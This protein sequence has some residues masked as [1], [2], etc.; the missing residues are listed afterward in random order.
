MRRSEPKLPPLVV[1]TPRIAALRFVEARYGVEQQ[2]TEGT[3]ELAAFQ[4]EAVGRAKEALQSRG[5]V[6][7]ADSVG[8]GKTYVALALI[9]EELERGGSALVTTPAALRSL[10][11]PHL[12]R[13]TS[14]HGSGRI[15][16]VSHTLLS[17]GGVPT[18]AT[19]TL[20]LVVVD[21]AH[22]FRNRRT[23]RY[24]ALARLCRAARVV[25]ITA[26]PVNNT[27]LDLYSLIRLFAGDG[28]FHDVGLADLRAAFLAAALRPDAPLPPAVHAMLR[29]VLIRRT[30]PLVRDLIGEDTGLSRAAGLDQSA[31]VLRFPR[32]A[33]PSAVRYDLTAAY[34]GIYEDAADLLES[35]SFAPFRLGCNASGA[36]ELLRIMLLKRLESSVAALAASITAQIRFLESFLDQLRTGRLLTPADHRA[37]RGPADA[38]AV[39]LL[40]GEMVLEPIPRHVDVRALSRDASSD[41]D[42]LRAFSSRLAASAQRD[43]KLHRLRQLL[44]GSLAHERVLL[45]TEFRETARYLWIALRDKGG[46]GLIHGGGAYLG[47]LPCGRREVIER[48][49]PAANGAPEPPPREALRLLIATDVLAEGMNLQD[50]RHVISYDLPWNPMRLIQRI[51]RVDRLGSPHDMIFTHAFLP[52]VGL[53]RLLGLLARVRAK[54]DAVRAGVGIEPGL[55]ESVA[56]GATD[57]DGFLDRL[58][59]GDPGLLDDIERGEATRFESE[60]RL[61][62]AWLGTAERRAGAGDGNSGLRARASAGDECVEAPVRPAVVGVMTALPAADGAGCVLLAV[63]H[64]E[65][66]KFMRHDSSG[67]AIDPPSAFQML[68]A[69]LATPDC[70]RPPTQPDLTRLRGAWTEAL[71]FL[72]RSPSQPCATRGP[73]AAAARVLLAALG[74]E[75]GG[76][77]LELCRRV[78]SV[79]SRLAAGVPAGLEHELSAVVARPRERA[80]DA[81]GLCSVLEAL[82]G[83]TTRGPGEDDTVGVAIELLGALEFRRT[84]AQGLAVR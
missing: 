27:L 38:E 67:A 37:F 53:E 2:G 30:R 39:Q 35:L 14:A 61:R 11:R 20:G 47:R 77:G 57:H 74:R 52:D 55:L 9:E 21:E 3:F 34:P 16:W 81:E 84:N 58:A 71:R 46:V 50:A 41:L 17:R 82:L 80:E 70:G 45:F 54:L 62:L 49:A 43:T 10:W 23:R 59:T 75:P 68:E 28:A 26:T 32:R 4:E 18:E 8:L 65:V 12:Q 6:L 42:R 51:G 48:F 25:L 78:E 36:A 24:R 5:G 83:R 79:L 31:R 29:T 73:A 19:K 72:R 15:K 60:E 64:G 66:L 1:V 40:F 13:L 7:I 22:A 76:P 44:D 69:A 33:P 63:R 56:S